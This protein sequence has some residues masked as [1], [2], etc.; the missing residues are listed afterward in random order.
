MTIERLIYLDCGSLCPFGKSFINGEGTWRDRGYLPCVCLLLVTSKGLILIDTGLGSADIRKPYRRLGA[1]R[2]A[3]LAPTLTLA[4]T[5]KE[6]IKALGY[7]P[8]DVRDII[9]T[10]LDVDHIGGASDF[11]WARVHVSTLE[12]EEAQRRSRYSKPQI[13]AIRN[14]QL[15][16]SFG[17]VWFG[18]QAVRPVIDGLDQIVLVPLPGHSK[19][20]LGVGFF[21]QGQWHFHIGDA[22]YHLNE[23]EDPSLVPV[24]LQFFSRVFCADRNLYELNQRRLQ[25]LQARHQVELI[26]SHHSPHRLPHIIESK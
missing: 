20:Q 1:L 12:F 16:P 25:A 18:F 9:C 11:P 23:L 13:K 8:E 2:Y 6:Q 19:G 26:C 21:W 17:E 15:H 10:H 22:V 5:A 4:Q 7:Q 14:W 24:G 3:S